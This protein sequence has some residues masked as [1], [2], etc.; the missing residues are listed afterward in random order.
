VFVLQDPALDTEPNDLLNC[1][2]LA[3]LSTFQ[4]RRLT[5]QYIQVGGQQ[6]PVYMYQ[7]RPDGTGVP[8]WEGHILESEKFFSVAGS[9]SFNASLSRP[10]IKKTRNMLTGGWLGSSNP[11]AVNELGPNQRCTYT[12]ASGCVYAMNLAKDWVRTFTTGIDSSQAGSIAINLYFK[13]PTGVSNV[14]SA[15]GPGSTGVTGGTGVR[16]FNLHMFALCDAVAT[17]QETANLVR[18]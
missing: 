1:L 5:E 17:L 8:Y 10:M 4:N 18:Y 11:I 2:A 16:T 15:F 14:S 12:D 9:A 3:N 6:Y 7:M 13:D